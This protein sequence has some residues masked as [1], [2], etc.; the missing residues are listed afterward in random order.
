MEIGREMYETGLTRFAAAAKYDISPY[1]ARDYL[2]EYK[3][4]LAAKTND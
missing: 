2:R 3:A 4:R 1:T